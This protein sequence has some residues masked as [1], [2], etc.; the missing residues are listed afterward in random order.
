MDIDEFDDDIYRLSLFD[1]LDKYPHIDF[2]IGREPTDIIHPPLGM[3]WTCDC[4]CGVVIPSYFT[5]GIAYTADHNGNVFR[6]SLEI[7]LASPCVKNSGEHYGVD[8]YEGE[9]E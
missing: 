8:I 6:C 2:S 5:I 7:G 4:G 3:A 1:L 9:Q